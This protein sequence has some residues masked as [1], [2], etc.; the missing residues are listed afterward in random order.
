[1]DIGA[2]ASRHRGR[3]QAF[4]A[5]E[6][7]AWEEKAEAYGAFF[8][9][10]VAKVVEPLLDAAE[11]HA[12]QGQRVL[13]LATGPGYVAAAAARRGA[14]CVGVDIAPGMV[15]LARRLHPGLDVRQGD[16][17]SLPLPD[18]EFDAV[19]ANLAVMHMARPETAVGEA[20]RVLAPGGRLAISVWDHPDRARLNGLF[21]DALVEADA[22]APDVPDGPP[23]YRFADVGER[24]QLLTRQGLTEVRSGTVAFAHRFSSAD[25]LWD[26]MLAATVRISAAV[27]RQPPDVQQR[28]RASF[29]RLV[30]EYSRGPAVEIPISISFSSGR[31][32]P[33]AVDPPPRRARL[34]YRGGPAARTAWSSLSSGSPGTPQPGS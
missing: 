11:V 20:V 1:M 14:S 31:K 16:M 8:A 12:G 13:D 15:A 18:D 17:E 19:V 34:A 6:A 29:D 23:F 32:P 10:L 25:H 26:G 24:E 9:P 3:D 21:A 30:A 2:R 33:R 5:F 27:L 28:I 22:P 7:A 4:T